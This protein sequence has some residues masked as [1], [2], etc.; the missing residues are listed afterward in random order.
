MCTKVSNSPSYRAIAPRLA[1]IV[2]ALAFIRDGTSVT[3]SARSLLHTRASEQRALAGASRA[4]TGRMCTNVS[5][6]SGNDGLAAAADLVTKVRRSLVGLRQSFV[7]TGASS[8]PESASSGVVVAHDEIQETAPY[9]PKLA[10]PETLEPFLKH[11]EP[12]SDG[13]P[14]ERD[15]RELEARLGELSDAL[16]AGR[17]DRVAEWLL[18]SDFR[19]G[20]LLPVDETS[21]NDGRAFEVKRARSIPLEL[22]LSSASFGGELRRL[23]ENLR[24][25]TVAEL[26]ITSIDVPTTSGLV[27]TDV[28]YDIVGAGAKAWR[29]QHVGVWRMS[30]RKPASAWQVVEWSAASH[31]TSRARDPIF[32]EVTD[33]A[34]GANDS[35]RRQLTAGLDAWMATLDSVLTRDSNGHHG[36]S[37]GDAD[38]DGLEDLYV[39]QPAG[40][41]NHLYR[42][43]GDSTFEDIT[44]RAGLDVLDDTAQSLFADVDNDGDQD[45]VVATGTKPLLFVNSGKGVFSPVPDGFRFNRPLQGVLTSMSMADYDRDGFLDLYLCVYSYFFGAGEDKAGTPAPYYDA[46]NGPPGILFRNDRHGRFTDVTQESGLDAGNDRYHFAAAWADYNGDGWPDLLVANDFG[47]KNLYRNRGLRDGKVTFEDV[48]AEAGVLDHGAGMSAAFLDYDNDGLLDIYT[49][50]MWSASGQRITSAPTFMPDAP[51]DVRA[52]YRRHA[53][54]NSLFRNRGDGRFEE[55]T[56]DARVE[57]GRWAWSSEALDFDSDGWEDL[58][59]VNGML[60]REAPAGRSNANGRGEAAGM[61]REDVRDPGAS[62]LESF[63]WR[64]VVARSPLTRV[65]GTPYDDAWRAINQLLIHGSIASRQ[66]N[67]FLRNDGQGGFDD[68]S[69]AVGLDLDQD[70][71]S[72]AVLDF[73]RD[74]DP[75]LVVMAARQA[76][77]LRVFRNDFAPRG[78]SLAIRLVGTESNR[79]AIGTRVTVETERLRRTRIVQAGSGFLSQHSKELLL[80]LGSS[81]QVRRLT[82]EWP[83]GR[84]QVFTDVPLR[85]RLHLVE[86]GAI[87]KEPFASPPTGGTKPATPAAGPPTATWLY[88]PFP[89][90]DFSLADVRGQTRSLTAIRG[91]PIVLLF[92]STEVSGSRIAL[93]ALAAASSALAQRG[94]AALGIA[95]DS[96]AELS[97]MRAASLGGLPVIAANPELALSYAILNRHVFMNRQDLRLPTALLLDAAGMVVKVYRDHIDIPVILNDVAM[98]EAPPDLRLRRAVPFR[99]TFYSPPGL[100]NYLPYG[101]ELLDQGLETAAVVAFERAAQANPSASTLYRLGT[102][103]AKTGE[104]G[105]AR[106]AF[107]RALALQP[108]LAEANNDLGTLLAQGGEIEAAINRFRAALASTP[109]YPD[110]LNNLGYALLLTG[111]DEEART[112]YEKAL[113]LQ[114]D[115]PE[116]LNN[117]GLLFGRNGQLDRAE[118]HFREALAHRENYG[119]AANNLALVLVARGETDAAIRLLEGFLEKSPQSESAYLTLAKVLLNAKRSREGISVLERLLQRN[120]THPVALE[121]LRQWKQR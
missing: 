112:L 89:A 12:G 81:E 110:A 98:I 109:E 76:P 78:A 116:A 86:G 85:C 37:V 99:G 62:D 50:N 28:R 87:E 41:P 13:F 64:Q 58:Y 8:Q 45:L 59:V 60:T 97:K 23:L 63:F 55:K 74:G 39:A 105:R 104:T 65:K 100:R 108:D 46:R 102:L 77:Q 66:R 101:R 27:R 31:V 9:R 44:E 95:L 2:L 54:G 4:C 120:P 20:R 53:R 91:R 36:V 80:G 121:L 103:L 6:S 18:A 111:H 47:T 113:A 35:F 17:A 15:A 34:L 3:A 30:W 69:G 11:L 92:W 42:A 90:P 75:D 73:D 7:T 84:K 93:E 1:L 48:A 119:E 29:V 79:D 106:A 43:R 33:A 70:G 25:V 67:V 96:A 61:R 114:P 14:A 21:S 107:E 68:V 51:P 49:G 24:E 52:L 16:R 83:S 118:R 26:S 82:V 115:F 117:L 38:G 19:G 22:S 71:R 5:D 57:M 10:I 88:E 32:A 94:V 40:L 56:L 72:F